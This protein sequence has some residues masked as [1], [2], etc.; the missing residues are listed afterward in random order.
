MKKNETKPARLLKALNSNSLTTTEITGRIGVTPSRAR[1]IINELRQ[2]G[3]PILSKK[4]PQGQR[5]F[6]GQATKTMV[7]AAFSLYGATA[8]Q[9]S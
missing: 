2:Q 1:Y 9:V 8:F 6:V 5:Y 7:K 4:T 3:Y